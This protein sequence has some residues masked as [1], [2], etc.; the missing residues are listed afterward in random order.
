MKKTL[1]ARCEPIYPICGVCLDAA[2]DQSDE[3]LFPPKQTIAAMT[4]RRVRV[5]CPICGGASRLNA[6]HREVELFGAR[7]VRIASAG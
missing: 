2:L 6:P 4:S 5:N 7:S 1:V 3:R